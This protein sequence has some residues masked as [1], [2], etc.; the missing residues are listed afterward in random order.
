MQQVLV[1][2]TGNNVDHI[3]DNLG[4]DPQLAMLK[5]EWKHTDPKTYIDYK[6]DLDVFLFWNAPDAQS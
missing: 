3:F 1:D 6:R 5:I 4:R 2:K